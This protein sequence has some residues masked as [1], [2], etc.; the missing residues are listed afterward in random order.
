M[1]IISGTEFHD[2]LDGTAWDD[3]L[4]GLEGNDS[5]FGGDGDDTLIGGLG[6]DTLDGGQD[7]RS[8]PAPDPDAGDV[9]VYSGRREDYLIRSA[10]LLEGIYVIHLDGTAAFEGQDYLRNIEYLQFSDRRV[11][12]HG[13]EGYLFYGTPLDDSG[14]GALVGTGYGERILGRDGDDH[15]QGEGGNDTL[16]GEDGEDTLIGGAG[17]DSLLGGLGNDILEGGAGNDRLRGGSGDLNIAVF[18]G[19]QADYDITFQQNSSVIVTDMTPENGDEGRDVLSEI[20]IIRFA[21]GDVLH[22][23]AP[24]ARADYAYYDDE[25]Y[26]DIPLSDLLA[27]DYDPEGQALS[28]VN[29]VPSLAGMLIELTATYL[30][31]HIPVGSRVGH[32]DIHVSDGEI[33]SKSYLIINHR[34][35]VPTEVDDETDDAGDPMLPPV[36]GGDSADSLTGTAGRDVLEGGSGE[37]SLSGGAGSDLLSGDGGHD[38]IHGGAGHDTLWAGSADSDIYGRDRI[39]GG[40]GNDEIHGSNGANRLFGEAGDDTLHGGDDDQTSDSDRLEGGDGDDLLVSGQTVEPTPETLSLGDLLDGG[41]GADTL[42]GGTA[43]DTLLGGEGNDSLSG[44]AGNDLLSGED[45]TDTIYGGGGNDTITTGGVGRPNH[46][47]DYAFGEAGDDLITGGNYRSFL[48]GG[49]GNDTLN[50]GQELGTHDPDT[51]MG[52]ERR[53]PDH[54]GR[55]PQV[56]RLLADARRSSVRRRGR[57]HAAGRARL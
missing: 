23:N 26:I 13:P 44:G 14:A 54:L 22:N 9:V 12:L 31:V 1:P 30:R 56:Q 47:P 55:K 17:N 10:G 4:A 48:S 27:N 29:A 36:V 43:E 41:R 24:V 35:T 28:V 33:T 21:D 46:A 42:L 11:S 53:R 19:P 57:G 6:N 20:Q 49:A 15:L 5:L 51:L 34:E 18:A 25:P 2:N 40:S 37:D 52:G 50:G 39:W 45:G 16:S 32:I 38:W 3:R 7:A 8:Q